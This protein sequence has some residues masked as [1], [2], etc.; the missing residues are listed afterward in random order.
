[1]R[2][3]LVLAVSLLASG[4]SGQTM[5][6]C[7]DARGVT[8]YTDRPLPGCKGGEVK[9]QGQPPISGTLSPPRQDVGQQE[10]DY[11]RRKMDEARIR[12]AQRNTAEK[13]NRQCAQLQAE[14]EGLESGRRIVTFNDK[15]EPSYLEDDE[16]NQRVAKLREEIALKCR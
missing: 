6:K 9:I 4:A 13:I 3:V 8:H 1:M 15:G 10:R 14:V 5:H 7:V 11:Q 12:E 2:L 16:R